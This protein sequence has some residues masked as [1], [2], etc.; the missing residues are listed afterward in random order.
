M[1]G[2]QV[3][4]ATAHGGLGNQLL[5]LLSVAVLA[6][7]LSIPTCHLRLASFRYGSR[8]YNDFEHALPGL[9][10]AVEPCVILAPDSPWTHDNIT[11]AEVAYRYKRSA[12]KVNSAS[13][14][15]FEL[16]RSTIHAAC[17]RAVD[18]SKNKGLTQSALRL[19]HYYNFCGAAGLVKAFNMPASVY[20][21]NMVAR[22]NTA[23]RS[24]PAPR[25]E[26][27]LNV[28][29]S[30][31]CVHIRARTVEPIVFQNSSRTDGRS[32]QKP[33]ETRCAHAFSGRWKRDSFLGG[34]YERMLKA[35][36]RRRGVCKGIQT[37][38]EPVEKTLNRAA[39]ALHAH[40][41]NGSLTPNF[42][43][44]FVASPI[45]VEIPR[46]LAALDRVE[47][48]AFHER[49]DDFGGW[50]SAKAAIADLKA[51][52]SCSTVRS[53]DLVTALSPIFSCIR[54]FLF[55]FASLIIPERVCH[56]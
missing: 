18:A 23:L 36:G 9:A 5:Y 29:E 52:S 49:A 1:V 47:V 43:S 20:W 35:Q 14:D 41:I 13:N 12:K 21:E 31:L 44:L 17:V 22:A 50:T 45:P 7:F 26:P 19:D 51:L 53:V 3:L 46:S 32:M 28:N 40:R 34:L 48:R 10:R 27:F 55:L 8:I 15:L 11:N 2:C 24:K 6:N 42:Q 54:F 16:K 30:T 37:P 39:A 38:L 25:G 33:T 56:R 4:R